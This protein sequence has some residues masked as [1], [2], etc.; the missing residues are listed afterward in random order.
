MGK[1]GFT[2]T[3]ILIVVIIAAVLVALIVPRGLKAIAQANYVND[4]SN[5]D[6]IQ[7]AVLLCWS[8]KRNWGSCDSDTDLVD[9]KYLKEFP[10]HP[11]GGTYSIITPTDGTDGREVSNSKPCPSTGGTGA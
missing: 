8:E 10:K 1:K 3:K 5:M 11:C 7:E 4:K 2:L 9:G 6:T